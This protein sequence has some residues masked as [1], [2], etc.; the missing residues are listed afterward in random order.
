MLNDSSFSLASDPLQKTE[1]AMHERNFSWEYWRSY[2]GVAIFVLLIGA[3]S[4]FENRLVAQDA[5]AK[6]KAE[7]GS[8]T[9]DIDLSEFKVHSQCRLEVVATE[10][11]V[12]DPIAIEFD[13]LGRMWVVEMR[14]YPTLEGDPKS[15]IKVLEDK[16]RD[17]KFETATV[18]ADRLLFPTGL[19]RWKDGVI[20]TLEGEIAFFRD[21]NGD[22]KSDRKEVWF[23]GFARQ[24]TQLRAN[25]PTFAP[26]GKIYVANGLRNGEVKKRGTSTPVS[27]RGMDFRFDPSNLS[28]EPVTGYGQ[29]GLT[30]DQW[31]NR[32]T[33]TNR[34]P[35][36]RVVFEDRYLH[37]GGGKYLRP[38]VFD[39]AAAGPDSRLY[40]L[41]ATWTTSNLHAN[42]F[43]AA[44]GV[45][46]YDGT[47]LPDSFQGN[48]FTCDPT[49]YIV[50]REVL[51]DESSRVVPLSKPG[52]DGVEFLASE[53][54][55]F[56]PVNLSTGPEGALYVVDMRR[57]VIE[58]P[59]FMPSELKKRPDL[60]GGSQLGR[61]Y[62]IVPKA[63]W[64][65]GTRAGHEV[66]FA[67]T[68]SCVKQLHSA[69]GWCRSTAHRLLSQKFD[70]TPPPEFVEK[71]RT[72]MVADSAHP[73]GVLRTMSLLR[74][75]G[76]LK[77][78]DLEWSCSHGSA[79]VRR[80]AVE[81]LEPI[82]AAKK[83]GV[84]SELAKRLA[85]RAINDQDPRVQ[86]QALLTSLRIDQ[87]VR[88]SLMGIL[89]A[90]ANDRWMQSVITAS[91][92]E[93]H[94]VR[95]L[96]TML[97]ELDS[98]QLEMCLTM[99]KSLAEMKIGKDGETLQQ[100]LLLQFITDIDNR[101][102]QEL[103]LTWIRRMGTAARQELLKQ[104]PATT[105]LKVESVMVQETILGSQNAATLLALLFPENKT[106]PMQVVDYS[107]PKLQVIA[108][109][110]L[111]FG[112]DEI[113]QKLTQRFRQSGPSLKTEILKAAAAR[114]A[115][116][117][118]VLD[119][120]NSGKIQVFELDSATQ[121]RLK[122]H[123]DSS[124]RAYAQQVLKLDLGDRKTVYTNFQ[125]A[126][127]LPT[128]AIAGRP[129]FVKRC[130][131]CHQLGQLGNRIGPDIS[132]TRTKTKSQLLHD[133]L[134]PNAAID[135]AFVEYLVATDDGRNFSGVISEETGASVTLKQAN[136][137]TIVLPRDQIERMESTGKSLMPI[138]L[139]KDLTVQEVANLLS[140]LKNWR[141]LEQSVPYQES[142]NAK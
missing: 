49:A 81:Q 18:F 48:F 134:L 110:A 56:R 51:S 16:D 105:K 33:C 97:E 46:C 77:P 41:A 84:D 103:A 30:F 59:D 10:P 68:V 139:E 61:I 25:H 58:H 71:I 64:P 136:N 111:H 115:V 37:H 140:F 101:V 26:D 66:S 79:I 117:R 80:A 120:V 88:D 133:I 86:F 34:N 70:T 109:R 27:I 89:Q 127:E 53:N 23:S 28:C 98:N 108:A 122:S 74:K 1:C 90:N 2:S 118:L 67:S 39:I 130:A 135:S 55:F 91:L 132:D 75:W 116:A 6:E 100:E 21:T 104:I 63:D 17:G 113:W 92:G 12:V 13:E 126:V 73:N 36:K 131:S 5:G 8:H 60:R 9:A 32:Y 102:H 31:G 69:N 43:T 85:G 45:H 19:Q 44:C 52:R 96:Q 112:P 65:E 7:I 82:V 40:P 93:E 123:R 42:Q 62:R 137:E 138:G 142:E 35:V 94:G 38:T 99:M 114:P 76:Q 124:L 125:K 128:K 50:H 47:L 119:L 57:E 106:L 29:F 72:A 15:C 14:D 95:F 3:A 83:G 107:Q 54:Q 24:N 11:Q 87:P 129:I 141:Y 20:V 4:G 78:A 22:L 121:K